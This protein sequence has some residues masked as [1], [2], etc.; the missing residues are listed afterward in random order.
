MKRE[1]IEA[2]RTPRGGWTREQ[3]AE[4]GV[5]WPPPKGWK[6]RLENESPPTGSGRY[7]WTGRG[8]LFSGLT[9][10]LKAVSAS[11]VREAMI[12]TG[13]HIYLYQPESGELWRLC[14]DGPHRMQNRR[15]RG[16]AAEPALK[17]GDFE[18]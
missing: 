1:D 3:L 8:Q 5:P 12:T 14:A 17:V 9:A 6:K 13:S 16:E 4:W 7:E 15:Y 10:A 11:S 2:R 18:P